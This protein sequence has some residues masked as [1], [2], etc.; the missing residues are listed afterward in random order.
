[1]STKKKKQSK[2]TEPI[3]HE[4]KPA[5][6]AEDRARAE[7]VATVSKLATGI[8]SG[9]VKGIIAIAITDGSGDE[10]QLSFAGDRPAA[11][12]LYLLQ[13]AERF[14]LDSAIQNIRRQGV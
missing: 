8:Q 3:K 11:R 2:K 10:D 7:L 14:V 13:L 1:M 6:S 4:S 9:K 5:A 12:S